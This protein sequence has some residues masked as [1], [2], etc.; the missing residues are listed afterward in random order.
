MKT[1][2]YHDTQKA[3]K[4]LREQGYTLRCPLN[5]KHDVLTQELARITELD[6][7]PIKPGY[8]YGSMTVSELEQAGVTI[9]EA[10]TGKHI[11]EYLDIHGTG[12][13][14][15]YTYNGVHYIDYTGCHNTE[16]AIEHTLSNNPDCEIIEV[17]GKKVNKATN[18]VAGFPSSVIPVKA[19]EKFT[20]K[21][22]LDTLKMENYTV[23]YDNDMVFIKEYP[24]FLV[25][26]D[27]QVICSSDA[28][29]D[30]PIPNILRVA[31]YDISHKA[32]MKPEI[33]ELE[34]DEFIG[35]RYSFWLFNESKREYEYQ[36]SRD[37]LQEVYESVDVPTK[38]RDKVDVR[39][40]EYSY[41]EERWL[42]TDHLI[43]PPLR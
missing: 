11:Q 8:D 17:G 30:S 9:T 2:S 24:G 22:V 31:G 35:V 18:R 39:T 32:F 14:V 40:E 25:V 42:C 33:I 26:K 21:S 13:V 27:T 20:V 10:D 43:Y 29:V 3:L 28:L 12:I 23:Y 34:D 38:D 15:K 36:H 37:T 4:A 16:D 1:L 6:N 41:D 19:G 7:A 5:S